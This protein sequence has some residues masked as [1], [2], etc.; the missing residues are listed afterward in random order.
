MKKIL[1]ALTIAISCL[2]ISRVSADT[3]NLSH[4]DTLL[5]NCDFYYTDFDYIKVLGYENKIQ[6]IYR[7]LL[8]EYNANY[9][10]EYPYF[11]V[12]IVVI[13]EKNCNSTS[14][15]TNK[16]EMI[17]GFLN[18]Y[19]DLPTYSG[20]L[21]YSS[22]IIYVDYHVSSTTYDL[23]QVT[24]SYSYPIF[25]S[26]SFYNP[27]AYFISNFDLVNNTDN[28][29]FVSG[30]SNLTIKPGDIIE[31]YYTADKPFQIDYSEI[32]LNDYAYVILSLKNYEVEPFKTTIQVKGQ[33]CPTPVYRL[34]TASSEEVFGTGVKDICTPYYDT[35]TPYSLSYYSD[36][37]E[38]FAMLYVKA[39][40]TTKDNYIKVDNRIFDITYVSEEE[41]D[42]PLVHYQGNTIQTIPY[43]KLP[44][45]SIL[46]TQIGYVP[47][48]GNSFSFD[49]IFTQPLKFLTGIWSTIVTFFSLITS[50]IALMPPELRGF[51]FASF[52]LGIALGIVK[53]II[54]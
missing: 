15:A 39:Y 20:T 6:E 23:P 51:L 12:D 3:F 41:K 13:D 35:Y 18:F 29:Y 24:T 11:Y 52:T 21:K 54:G 40:D 37:L 27:M 14:S 22:S 46:N 36:Y 1:I 4:N 10:S 44:S 38:K 45:T 28:T 25:L 48:Y 16:I 47:D 33:F 32:N 50:F 8:E 30:N 26:N 2:G 43:D 49:D 17:R 19:S 7:L 31:P 34:G 5:H 42:S 9:A 53:I